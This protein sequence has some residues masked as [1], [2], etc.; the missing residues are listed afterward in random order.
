MHGVR[1][2]RSTITSITHINGHPFKV[3]ALMVA[4]VSRTELN[5]HAPSSHH[6][7]LARHSAIL[8]RPFAAAERLYEGDL[9]FFV[10]Q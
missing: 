2:Y 4:P 9:T 3:G 1:V 6:G 10:R 8:R 7:Y 5:W